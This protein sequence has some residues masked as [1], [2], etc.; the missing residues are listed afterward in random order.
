MDRV[1]DELGLVVENGFLVLFFPAT[2]AALVF[3]V[4]ARVNKGFEVFDYG[5]LPI[6]AGSA[7]T[8]YLG[9]SAVAPEDGVLP[10][11]SYTGDVRFP[12]IMGLE[13][14]RDKSDVWY[15]DK[16]DSDRLF[17]VKV[18]LSPP[19]IRADVRIP[20][21]VSQIRFQRERVV[22]GVDGPLGF[23][24]GSLEVVHLPGLI[25]GYRFG[26]DTSLPLKVYS[27]FVYAEYVVETPRSP[28]LIFDVLQRRVPSHWLTMPVTYLDPSIRSALRDVYGL[29][30]PWGFRLYRIDERDAAIKE[31]SAVLRRLKV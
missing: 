3:R 9:G 19:I 24:R 18:S 5:P 6:A 8:T 16:D 31:Y 4:R 27:R 30:E 11:Y 13:N 12:A 26:N 28:E 14:V 22:G 17:H 21:G 25:Y 15:L 7:L 29:S 1:V 10:P 2:Q 20:S 23:S